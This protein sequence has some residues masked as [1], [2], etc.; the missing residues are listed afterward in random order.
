MPA[1]LAGPR[2]YVLLSAAMSADGYL[3]DASPRRLI[4]SGPEDLDRVDEV[5]A[6]CDAIMVGAGT[7]RAD[8]PR[9]LVRSASRREQRTLRGLPPD[10]VKVTVTRSGDLDPQ[11]LFFAADGAAKL[12]YA[13]AES[14]G[15]LDR[16]LSGRATVITL[17]AGTGLPGLLADLRARGI[18]RLMI[19]G[20]AS[21]LGQAL[22]QGLADEL[23]LAVAPVLVADPAAPRLLAGY[24]RP[25]TGSTAEPGLLAGYRQP[26]AG[27]T[28]EPGLLANAGPLPGRMVLA[29]LERAGDMA[30]L[31]YL[32]GERPE[33]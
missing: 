12:V 20:G 1:G 27:S 2:P 19:E 21:V 29:G 10:L 3:D 18:G 9:L 30:V 24:R 7:I 28:A 13:S 14:A 5:R 33:T 8:N 31:R 6:G 26:A 22:A 16:R 4:L 15:Q 25:A 11:A 23:Q 32:V 17:A